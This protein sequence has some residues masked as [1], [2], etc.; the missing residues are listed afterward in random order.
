MAEADLERR[1]KM[2][3]KRVTVWVQRFRD[4]DTLMLQW[5]DP[6]TGKRKS[7]SAGTCDPEEASW[8]ARQLERELN[9]AGGVA[10]A[11]RRAQSPRGYVYLIEGDEGCFKI[12]KSRNPDARVLQLAAGFSGDL[13]LVHQIQTDDMRWLEGLL[14]RKFA[15]QRIRGEW[16][17][18]DDKDLARLSRVAVWN[19]GFPPLRAVAI[20]DDPWYV[21]E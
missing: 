15:G 18:L 10:V 3:E 13:G 4:R 19:K 17:A 20:V 9:E 5:L 2:V 7:K 14:H 1:M 21:A 11:R 6:G 12:G 8:L 16:F